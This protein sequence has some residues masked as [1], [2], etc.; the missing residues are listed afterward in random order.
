[1]DHAPLVTRLTIG[2]HR[3][4][5]ATS[6]LATIHGNEGDLL[7]WLETRL[8]LIPARVSTPARIRQFANRLA[9]VPSATWTA[10]LTVDR[11]GTAR[12]LLGVRDQLLLSG[13]QGQA[14]TD[15]RLVAEL[16]TAEACALPLAPGLAERL[17][18]VDAALES[19]MQLPRHV[20]SLVEPLTE[21]L[22]AW[23][24]VL[25]S[26]TT[27]AAAAAPVPTTAATALTAVQSQLAGSPAG[28]VQA[29]PSLQW[30]QAG[31]TSLAVRTVV[32]ALGAEPDE[33]ATTVLC[34]ADDD[35]AAAVDEG[36]A[37]LGLPTSGSTRTTR[38]H[39]VLQVLPLSIALCWEPVDPAV[40]M[41][42]LCLPVSPVPPFAASRLASA[43]AEQPGLGSEAWQQTVKELTTVPA[44]ADVKKREAIAKT[45]E[46]IATWLRNP[47]ARIG[48]PLSADLLVSRATSLA[49]W[50]QGKGGV[51]LKAK[52]V[53]P[54]D[55]ELA[56]LLLSL[57]STARELAAL[58]QADNQP[59][60]A[61]DVS[62]LLAMLDLQH[63]VGVH[64][65]RVGG[66]RRVRCMAE[67]DSPCARLIWLGRQANGV[68]AP[69]WS[70][71]ELV[72]LN[73]EG[74][75]LDD[76]AAAV[77]ALR[78]AE[79]SG[80]VRVTERL[81]LVDVVRPDE[82]YGHPLWTRI[83]HALGAEK[84]DRQKA[85]LADV[86]A[87]RASIAPWN[88]Q[89]APVA[90][91]TLHAPPVVWTVD[92]SLMT[93]RTS[94]SAS[95]L[96]SQLGCPLKWVLNY[97][98][99]LRQSSSAQ[100]PDAKQL[101][102]LFAHAVL[103]AVFKAKPQ[104]TTRADIEARVRAR[105]DERIEL[106]AAPLMQ[107]HLRRKRMMLRDRV[108]AAAG[109]LVEA[110]VRGGYVQVDT[111][112]QVASEMWG[113]QVKGSIDCLATGD[114]G[115]RA[116]VD[117]KGGK[118]GW[119]GQKLEKGQAIQL[120][121]YAAAVAKEFNVGLD[122]V[123]VAYLGLS[124]RRFA[125]PAASPV[126][127]ISQQEQLSKAPSVADAWAQVQTAFGASGNWLDDGHIPVRPLQNPDDW[128]PA[129]LELLDAPKSGQAHSACGY[130][131]F[132]LLCGVQEVQ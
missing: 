101:E 116:V 6:G 100:V 33:L 42:F 36:L 125:T 108:V 94:V 11:W 59:V 29:D 123:P 56:T 18:A 21:W 66:M 122:A 87:G 45:T 86:V 7:R 2:L 89:I 44:D 130:C 28:T 120:Y 64:P 88:A 81:V 104:L 83:H 35:L 22:P 49:Q 129:I 77:S 106:D 78:R 96:E 90:V 30:W 41:E 17:A 126:R 91:R 24:Q 19:G 117:F 75:H 12:H 53:T 3:S 14:V 32:A 76:G 105:F 109:H 107:P 110:L 23:Q 37:A 54:D 34:C 9:S 80:L 127:G 15:V 121:L 60:T 4:S 73:E 115:R 128:P 95:D 70:P 20:V 1:M 67:V 119:Y 93:D 118:V 48:Q 47:R 13:W 112:H 27:E 50:A 46:R 98:A 8:G 113:K 52:D 84:F 10:S 5:H 43:L 69:P 38:A 99:K 102:G 51:M 57:A 103:D 68:P 40:V 114:D 124:N 132:K 82:R 39:A 111:E 65:A 92:P 85:Q 31:S 72:A 62:R 97:Q 74:V 16:A 79:V 63:V 131:E 58:V 61:I 25:R 55:E 26:L 71:R